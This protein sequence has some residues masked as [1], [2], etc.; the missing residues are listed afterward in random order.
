MVR[1]VAACILCVL[2]CG[3]PAGSR[4]ETVLR[5]SASAGLAPLD[6]STG[7][8]GSTAA[9]LDLIYV[10]TSEHLRAPSQD[11]A[12]VRFQRRPQSGHS[13]Q[14]LADALRGEGLVSA[15]A[16][17]EE[18]VEARFRD[19]LAAIASLQDWK[20]L[21]A[22][23]PF[24][25]EQESE[26]RAVLKRRGNQP[27]DRIEIVEVSRSDEW[28]MLMGRELD[29]IPRAGA[30]YQKQLAGMDSLRVLDMKPTSWTALCFNVTHPALRD[31][32]VRS[33]IAGALDRAAIARMAC[34]SADCAAPAPPP[35]EDVALGEQVRELGI[36]VVDSDSTLQV[37]AS[38]LRHQ[39][40]RAGV[41]IA[42]ETVPLEELV[43]RFKDRRYGLLLGPLPI[44]ES[45]YARFLS[46]EA[47]GH[48]GMTG[49][50]SA[51]YDAAVA[52]GDLAAAQEI[53]DREVP[54]TPLYENR[55]FAAV[56]A[57]FCG[58][59]EPTESSWR[60]MADLYPC[61]EGERAQP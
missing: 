50:A 46:P 13:A 21:L 45:R 43:A 8:A 18:L 16:V 17:G 58:D 27:I 61:G 33:A 49:F 47:A 1:R 6:P 54:C 3:D 30:L 9:A 55:T 22:L 41:R 42:P 48:P 23:G 20:T 38:V 56:D 51:E 15:K 5:V 57:R 29:V 32:A 40:A 19:E 7:R 35:S 60:W 31:R 12:M 34:G 11:G 4:D 53:L 52:A 44:G 2:A 28:R 24:A 36:L 25:V 10:P 14:E 59:V 39:L 37:A 26:G